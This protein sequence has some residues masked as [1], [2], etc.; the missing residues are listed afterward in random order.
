MTLN[1]S[2]INTL[3]A[4]FAGMDKQELDDVLD[5]LMDEAVKRDW[6][7]LMNQQPPTRSFEQ[8]QG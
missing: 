3:N 2:T 5:L 4:L 1:Q 8:R 7:D 6:E